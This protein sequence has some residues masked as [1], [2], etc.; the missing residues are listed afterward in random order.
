[1]F[2]VWI[3][4]FGAQP[5][6]CHGWLSVSKNKMFGRSSWAAFSDAVVKKNH[7]APT[8]RLR[9]QLIHWLSIENSEIGM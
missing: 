1:M 9:R 2:G 3:I 4:A 5:N 6:A 7:S 8:K